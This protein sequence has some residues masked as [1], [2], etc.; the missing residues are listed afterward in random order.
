M[1]KKR[2]SRK[3]VLNDSELAVVYRTA[4]ERDDTFSP[5]SRS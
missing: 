1:P 3:R 4:L 5:S 2:A